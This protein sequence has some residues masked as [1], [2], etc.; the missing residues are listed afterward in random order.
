MTFYE[1]FEI[2]LEKKHMSTADVCAKTGLY[3][4]YFSKLKSGKFKDVTWEKALLIIAAL[5]MTPDE[6]KA[7]GEAK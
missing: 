2:A 4:S 1:L 7:L 6:F 3:P 5:E